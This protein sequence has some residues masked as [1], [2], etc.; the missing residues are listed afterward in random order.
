MITYQPKKK[1]VKRE[2][3]LF[4]VEGKILGRVASEI[5]SKLIGKDKV[6]YSRHMDSGNYVVV[7]N[8]KGIKV[9]GKKEAQKVYRS[10]SGYPGGLKEVKYSKMLKESPIKIIQFAVKG[11]LPDNRLKDKRM[12]RLKVF[13]GKLHPYSDKFERTVQSGSQ[14]TK[15]EKG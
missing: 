10:H 1:E 11:M 15:S 8:A 13:S 4:D 7:I 14:D 3:S 12:A 9:T 5:A 2:W 6:N